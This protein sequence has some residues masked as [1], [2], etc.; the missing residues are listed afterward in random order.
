MAA[1]VGGG[2]SVAESAE[3][4]VTAIESA[5][6][7]RDAQV[8]EIDGEQLVRVAGNGAERVTLASNPAVIACARRA[9][10]QEPVGPDATFPMIAEL[11]A[12]GV[13]CVLHVPVAV[14][15]AAH[16]AQVAEVRAALEREELGRSQERLLHAARL[17]SIGELAAGLVHELAQPLNVVGGYVELLQDVSTTDAGR[18]RALTAMGRAVD[19]MS[20]LVDN[21][22][23]FSRGGASRV[24]TVPVHRFLTMARD[25]TGCALKRGV[26]V[27]C[28]EDLMVRGDENQLEQVVVNLV[29]NAL[30]AGGDPVELVA[31]PR[32]AGGA[33]IE[34][35]DRGPG[36]PEGL[37]AR[38]FEAFFTT[39]PPGQG[40]GLGL[41]VSA[42]IVRDHG[43]T[44][45]VGDREGGG[46]V[47]RVELPAA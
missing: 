4:A 5:L 39:K 3:V 23:S 37:R 15:Q 10:A 35:R 32:S 12:H 42:R 31:G 28:P 25:L 26:I 19:R 24:A 8:Y 1:V 6:G 38:I 33:W 45:V 14:V 7:V 44:L 47:F 29:A 9:P 16:A 34:V 17:S 11:A 22:R 46:A 18:N 30:Q 21:L 41:A 40:T 13:R 27:G 2:A 36:V 43:G 20:T